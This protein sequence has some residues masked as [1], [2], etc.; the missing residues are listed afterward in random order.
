MV[1]VVGPLCRRMAVT[2]FAAVRS[3]G[4][5]ES[6]ALLLIPTAG[7]EGRELWRGRIQAPLQWTPGITLGASCHGDAAMDV[8]HGETIAA[9]NSV[10]TIRK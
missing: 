7:G 2:C 10:G 8:G 3:G 5:I 4:S 9:A 1:A 6:A